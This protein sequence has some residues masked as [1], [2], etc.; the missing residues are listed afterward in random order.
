MAGRKP[1]ITPG[2]PREQ[3]LLDALKLGMT[4]QAASG[5]CDISY[6]TFYRMYTEDA[7]FL[8]A[9]ERA[10]LWAEGRYTAIVA[11]AAETQWQAAAWWL[12]RRKYETFARRD[13]V[14]MTID[15]RGEAR[16]LAAEFGLDEASVLAEAEA[17]LAR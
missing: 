14:D 6:S 3:A 1:K 16:R 10:E 5:T 2:G 4:R 13:R 8:E 17:I 15:Y 12:E 9:V 11:R 7:R